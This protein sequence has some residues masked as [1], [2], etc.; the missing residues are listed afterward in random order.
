MCLSLVREEVSARLLW[1]LMKTSQMSTR[2][3]GPKAQPRMAA[4]G[5]SVAAQALRPPEET[6]GCGRWPQLESSAGS[7][8]GPLPGSWAASAEA[9]PR[10]S[11]LA[12]CFE[13][14]NI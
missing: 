1:K 7:G 10:T 14:D 12:P 11:S 8:H 4:V 6:L 5:E 13:R 2:C 3:L 9:P